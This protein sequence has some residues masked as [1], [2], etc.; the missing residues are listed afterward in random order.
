MIKRV[1]ELAHIE[2]QPDLVD[3]MPFFE[4]DIGQPITDEPHDEANDD[5]DSTENENALELLD[6]EEDD[7]VYVM[8]INIMKK[9]TLVMMTMFWRSVMKTQ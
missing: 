4:W 7:N 3:G 9:I 5:D 1:E 2:K 8:K 6:M